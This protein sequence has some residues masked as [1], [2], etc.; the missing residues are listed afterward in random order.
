MS[1]NPA[2]HGD[3]VPVMI[4]SPDDPEEREMEY[5][6][7]RYFIKSECN[8]AG[9]WNRLD[10][11]DFG[12]S[13]AS[14]LNDDEIRRMF[15]CINAQEEL[16]TLRFTGC[17]NI[18][19]SCLYALWGSIT[20][21]H[22]DLSLVMHSSP[23]LIPA[24]PISEEIVI[25]ILASMIYSHLSSLQFLCFPYKWRGGRS[26]IF[27]RFLFC[28]NNYLLIRTLMGT[29]CRP[30]LS[31]RGDAHAEDDATQSQVVADDEVQVVGGTAVS[32]GQVVADTVVSQAQVAADPTIQPFAPSISQP[33][34]FPFI[35]IFSDI[36][37]ARGLPTT[38]IVKDPSEFPHM[39]APLLMKKYGLQRFTCHK[40]F[41]CICYDCAHDDG[42][43]SVQRHCVNCLKD[44]CADCGIGSYNCDEC[45]DFLCRGCEEMGVE[46][47]LRHPEKEEED[48]FAPRICEGCLKS[49]G[50]REKTS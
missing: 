10:F 49:V 18:T 43:H 11:A 47:V 8:A 41:D 19:G 40:C 30:A 22:L 29:L 44:Y 24:P 6:P 13:V 4:L 45:E 34:L 37:I 12:Y 31:G 28:Y 36:L 2:W 27:H 39:N 14:K 38:W 9:R 20:L 17:I 7:P 5:D 23:I 1:P 32:Q 50:C 15:Q 35:N 25:P 21:R 16:I 42:C 3:L 33:L 46:L 48:K 26:W